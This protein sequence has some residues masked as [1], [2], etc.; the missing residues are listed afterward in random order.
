MNA[1][2]SHG[3]AHRVAAPR[4]PS[5]SMAISG[6][7]YLGGISSF[8]F[9]G[10][11]AH[12]IL[13][14]NSAATFSLP[15]PS[16]AFMEGTSLQHSRYWVLPAAHPLI[17]SGSVSNGKAG[18]PRTAAFDCNLLA[19]HLAL[20]AD[21][22]VFG[23]VLFPGAG[24]METVLAAGTT[25][26]DSSSG[27]RPA[28]AI[29]G[30]AISS[31]LIISHPSQQ[32]AGGTVMRCSLN[33]AAGDFQLAHAERRGSKHSTQCAGGSLAVA[34]ATA[35]AVRAAAAVAVGAMAMRR[36][37]LGKILALAAGHAT[38]SVVVDTRL[39]T[40][41][42]LVPPPCMDACL[43]LGVAAP[44]CGAKVPVALGA[45]VLTDRHAA[46]G[47][48]LAGC[49]TAAYR[50]PAGQTDVSSFA[51]HASAGGA[52]ASLG[53]LETKVTKPKAAG[54]TAAAAS[55][56]PAEFLYE[57]DWEVASHPATVGTHQEPEALL[58]LGSS[59]MA[60]EL[61]AGPCQA[62]TAALTVVQQTQAAQAPA[63]KVGLPE[64]LS[65]GTSAAPGCP[66]SKLLAAGAV[67]GLLRVAATEHASAAYSLTTSD[68][69][70]A[71]PLALADTSQ[72]TET[73]ILS[74]KR[75]HKG[76]AAVPRLLPR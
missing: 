56:K 24:M 54:Q 60:L 12:A 71:V 48:E 31:P 27:S 57:V 41:G 68:R 5:A 74:T 11:N 38:G 34:A 13:G 47:T 22:V 25:T 69:M 45:F 4:Q 51:M 30:M 9:Q 2:A 62:A 70:S 53:S 26:L 1:A 75:V 42:Y 55:V 52:F 36:V 64:V 37:L 66:T 21:H 72:G 58:A 39:D 19:P 8:A 29:A 16:A 20:Y 63:L 65:C 28:L 73:G 40:D 3:E 33:P 59:I 43:H 7:L 46:A 49:T 6:G 23:R 15:G 32:Q 18:V 17:G 44:G 67:E 14:S 10:T 35:V 76:V 61:A 50:V